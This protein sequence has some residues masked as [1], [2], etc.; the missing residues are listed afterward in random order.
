[1]EKSFSERCYDLLRKVPKG[2]VTTYGEIA[3][4]LGSSGARAVGNAMNKN[5]YA[6]EVPCHRVVGA[7]GNIGGFASGVGNK[8]E[9][10]KGEGIRVVEGRVVDFEKFFYR[11]GSALC[12]VM[13]Y[14]TNRYAYSIT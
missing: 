14:V 7:G 3:R 11:F 4:A 9:L 10:L 8:I 12:K 13:T 5:P 6:P 2:R 1:M